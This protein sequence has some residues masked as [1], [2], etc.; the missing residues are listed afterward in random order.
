ME[1]QCLSSM[2]PKSSIPF[3]S[4]FTM[5]IQLEQPKLETCGDWWNLCESFR[6]TPEKIAFTNVGV[7]V[8]WC[9][10][11]ILCLSISSLC[12]SSKPKPKRKGGPGGLNKL[13]GVSPE[14][15]VIVGHPTLPRTEVRAHPLLLCIRVCILSSRSFD[16][17]M[18][19]LL[20]LEFRLWSNCGLT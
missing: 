14:L 17:F 10:L 4:S 11:V 13:C 8:F 7:L 1:A 16:L 15:Q 19:Y 12:C 3:S 2:W 9:L 18:Y 5:H 6:L 20:Y